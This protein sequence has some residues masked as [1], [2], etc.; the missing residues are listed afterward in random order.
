MLAMAGCATQRLIGRVDG[1]R[2]DC[3][4]PKL[5]IVLP[6]L[7]EDFRVED[8]QEAVFFTSKRL[9]YC[10]FVRW[11]PYSPTS[12]FAR[13]LAA[14]GREKGLRCVADLYLQAGPLRFNKSARILVSKYL[15]DVGGGALFV[16]CT[17]DEKD[18]RYCD[19]MGMVILLGRDHIFY[20]GHEPSEAV[21]FL[22]GHKFVVITDDELVRLERQTVALAKA[23]EIQQ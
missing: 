2:Y 9:G 15:P 13:Q 18:F 20:V 14:D 8:M 22:N 21:D 1:D 11:I 19:R 5:G 4:Q 7:R 17:W 3:D 23:V 6:H 16:A 10:H 12:A